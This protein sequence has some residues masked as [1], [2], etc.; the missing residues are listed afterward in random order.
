MIWLVHDDEQVYIEFSTLLSFEFRNLFA[1]SEQERTHL[2]S[3]EREIDIADS[4]I[5][6]PEPLSF[7]SKRKKLGGNNKMYGFTKQLPF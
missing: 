1:Q 5:C 7:R 2:V 3:G 6:L 4:S